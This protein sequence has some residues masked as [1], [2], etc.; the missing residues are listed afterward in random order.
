[1]QN[2]IILIV[3]SLVYMLHLSCLCNTRRIYDGRVRNFLTTSIYHQCH[4]SGNRGKGL[5]LWELNIRV[6]LTSEPNR[7]DSCIGDDGIGNDSYTFDHNTHPSIPFIYSFMHRF[8]FCAFSN[9]ECIA[10][11]NTIHLR[12]RSQLCHAQHGYLT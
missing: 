10:R 4:T 7:R 2:S 1:M 12:P 11:T 3:D 6:A 9:R 8:C 5:W